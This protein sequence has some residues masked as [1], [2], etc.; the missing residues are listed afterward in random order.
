V[1]KSLVEA[2]ALPTVDEMKNEMP[3]E[4]QR[5]SKD[6]A[7]ETGWSLN[8]D[9]IACYQTHAGT[10]MFVPKSLRKMVLSQY[11]GNLCMG[12]TAY[13]ERWTGL[14]LALVADITR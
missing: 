5:L 6:A 9:G 8:E 13:C 7:S 4:Q 3:E 2:P 1:I 14:Q 12:T 11:H 10:R